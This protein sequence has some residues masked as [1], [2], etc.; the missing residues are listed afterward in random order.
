[1]DDM[2]VLLE[3]GLDELGLA[4]NEELIEKFLLFENLLITENEKMNLTAIKDTLGIATRHFLDSVTPLCFNLIKDGDSVIDV[5]A[6]AGFPAAPLALMLPNSSFTMV[7]SVNKK[8]GFLNMLI[9]TLN[10]KNTCAVWDRA[11]IAAHNEIYR[12]QFDIVVARGLAHLSPLLEYTVPFL[13]VGGRV[14]AFKG[15]S[16]V[17][18]VSE[19]KKALAELGAE[20]TD[21]KEIHIPHTDK[22]HSLILIDKIKQTNL[23]YP[24]N[25]GI[26]TKKPL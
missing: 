26:P 4:Y 1:M 21:I 9:S 13:K 8:V 7:D 19:A 6:G 11:E 18:E 12:E 2:R 17:R 10:L 23:K 24:R 20:V 3:K 25:A 5:G 14:I 22:I 15:E 16:A